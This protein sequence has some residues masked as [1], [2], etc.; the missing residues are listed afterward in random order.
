MRRIG[1]QLTQSSSIVLTIRT[2]PCHLL[3]LYYQSSITL[4]VGQTVFIAKQ[5]A[6][7]ELASR[8]QQHANPGYVS[9]NPTPCCF[10]YHFCRDTMWASG[11]LA[12]FYKD[13]TEVS[14]CVSK[15]WENS[16]YVS[17]CTTNITCLCSDAEF[18]AVQPRPLQPKNELVAYCVHSLSCN[19]FIRNA[20][21][22]T[23]LQLFIIQSS[24]AQK[25][26]RNSHK[27][28]LLW[29]ATKAFAYEQS[30]ACTLPHPYLLQLF[31]LVFDANRAPW[32]PEKL[33]LHGPQ[34]LHHAE[35][36]LRRSPCQQAIV[37]GSM[38]LFSTPQQCQVFLIDRVDFYEAH[39]VLPALGEF[40]GAVASSHHDPVTSS[41][42]N[43]ESSI[44]KAT[45]QLKAIV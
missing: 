40:S 23:L 39:G 7:L 16:K 41:Q 18:Q 30:R 3:R 34:L 9:F 24:N 14:A 20:R 44:R 6:D 13:L 1:L 17:N 15:C 43:P 35:R 11:Y 21:P 37:H 10:M 33:A 25:M 12:R 26:I 2:S 42:F 45:T 4:R 32:R 27:T 29:F 28:C 19:V 8:A 38:Q 5:L 36:L 31:T 22:R